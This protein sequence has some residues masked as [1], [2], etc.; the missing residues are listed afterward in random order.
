MKR[1]ILISILAISPMVEAQTKQTLQEAMLACKPGTPTAEKCFRETIL[2]SDKCV[3]Y[4]NGFDCVK[5]PNFLSTFFS[6]QNLSTNCVPN[7]RG[8]KKISLWFMPS[9]PS[10]QTTCRVHGLEIESGIGL[11]FNHATKDKDG[12]WYAPPPVIPIG[13]R[14]IVKPEAIIVTGISSRYKFSGERG[15]LD[16]TEPSHILLGDSYDRLTRIPTGETHLVEENDNWVSRPKFVRDPKAVERVDRIINAYGLEKSEDFLRSDRHV[17]GKSRDFNYSVISSFKP[18]KDFKICGH[19]VP[20]GTNLTLSTAGPNYSSV[21][22]VIAE[23]TLYI[24][25]IPN[26]KN[27]QLE[28]EPPSKILS[29]V[30]KEAIATRFDDVMAP[31]F[32]DPN[33]ELPPLPKVDYSN[34]ECIPKELESDEFRD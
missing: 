12:K 33:A 16:Y 5:N 2:K 25:G 6:N 20:K 17:I 30:P 11:P 9:D 19:T 7:M 3:V 21:K 34:C 32:K 13:L 18:K 22:N 14:S 24:V 10:K 15:F 27:L 29:C 23:G 4:E 28:G 31:L 26:A 1:A 8:Y